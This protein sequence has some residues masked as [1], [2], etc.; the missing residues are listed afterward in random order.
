MNEHVT[1]R[2]ESAN[3]AGIF[4]VVSQLFAQGGDMHIDAAVEDLVIPLADFLQKLIA[5]FY[6]AAGPGQAEEKLVFHRGQGKGDAPQIGTAGRW[7]DAQFSNHN[8]VVGQR[9]NHGG[10]IG[11]ARD[12]TQARQEFPGGKCLG[13]VIVRA[14]FQA[15]DPV[16]F[17]AAGGE[18]ENGHPGGSTN[19]AQDFQAIYAGQ[20]HIENHRMPGLGQRLLHPFEAGVHRHY[21]VPHWLQ[22]FDQKAAEF[23][24]IIHHQDAARA[25]TLVDGGFIGRGIH[26]SWEGSRTKVNSFTQKRLRNLPFLNNN[27]G[28]PSSLL[29]IRGLGSDQFHEPMKRLPALLFMSALTSGLVPAQTT[30]ETKSTGPAQFWQAS[31]TAE[32]NKDYDAALN[33][34]TSYQ[35]SGG[36]AFLG[37]LRAAWLYYLKQD[38]KNASAHYL[39]AERLQP[40]SINPLLGLMNV[41]EA[42]GNADEIQKAAENVLH[43]DPLNYRA[44]MVSAYQQYTA[45]NY[46]MALAGYRRVLLYYPDDMTALSGEAW[47]LYYLGQG[48]KAATD[49]QTL[50]SVNSNDAWSQKG[51]A[52]CQAQKSY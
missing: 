8:I 13:Q 28:P 43:L 39:E 35:T 10:P 5:R 42:Q 24:I 52:L 45:K 37:H 12:G 51:L 41:S 50:L 34:I 4:G 1:R 18:H 23:F 32:T 44:Q 25:G 29:N 49:F 21:L 46:A 36:N 26:R 22:V 40:S 47:S 15:D 38:Y 9:L 33:Q 7:H 48:E 19:P 11:P 3:E 14:D 31:L 16:R 30:P 2:T 6:P 27:P 17:L 20:H